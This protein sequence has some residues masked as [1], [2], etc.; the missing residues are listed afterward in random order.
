[1]IR[2]P[3]RAGCAFEAAERNEPLV[4]TASRVRRWFLIEQ[5]GAWGR[6]ALAESELPVGVAAAVADAARAHGVRVLLVRDR[7]RERGAP[8]TAMLVRSDRVHR[9]IERITVEDPRQLAAVDLA[10]TASDHPP[11]VGEPVRSSVFLVCTNGRHDPCCA[12]LGRPVVRALRG[13]GFEVWESSHV[14]GDRFAANVV[15]LPTGVYYGRVDPDGAAAL[16]A[17][18]DRGVLD[19]DRFRGRSCFPPLVQAAEVFARRQL[20]ERGLHRLHLHG[21]T[22]PSPD[23]ALVRFSRVAGEVEVDVEVAVSRHLAPPELLTCSDRRSRPWRYQL[24]ELR[25]AAGS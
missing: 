15:C 2:D 7:S 6:D 25:V 12:D 23:A 8:A 18:H 24:D 21:V 16:L 14:G 22:R 19:L 9:W 3:A 4:A 11:G 10:A 20:D 13:A 1:V 5:P 17:D